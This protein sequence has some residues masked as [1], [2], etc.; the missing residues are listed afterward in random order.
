M[1][2][3]MNLPIIL[4]LN[5]GS[6]FSRLSNERNFADIRVPLLPYLLLGA[7]D[8]VLGPARLAVLDAGAVQRAAN[9]VIAHAGQVAHAAAADEHDRVLLQV[10]PLARNVGRGLSAAGEA[11]AGDLSQR[12]V[13]LLRRH[14]LHDE[15][16]AP[17]L[18]IGLQ[19][20]GLAL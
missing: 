8:A 9:D 14:R 2:Q 7:L 13:R 19:D 5:F 11:H 18:G 4:S 12:G 17:L 20:G 16:D 3:L 6:G 15:A 10:V 1:R